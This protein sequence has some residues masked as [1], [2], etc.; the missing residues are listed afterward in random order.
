[1]DAIGHCPGM[2]D[3]FLRNHPSLCAPPPFFQCSSFVPYQFA[4][5]CT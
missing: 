2:N 3:L 5:T 4:T 1:M